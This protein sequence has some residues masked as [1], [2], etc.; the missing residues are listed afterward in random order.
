[1]SSSSIA[2]PPLVDGDL[3]LRPP[4]EADVAA[5][6]RLCQDPDVQRFTRVPSPYTEN[7]ARSFL[8]LHADGIE[9]GTGVHLLTV[10]ITTDEVLGAV[11]GDI[12]HRDYSSEVGYWVGPDARGRGIATRGTRLLVRFLLDELDIRY[13]MLHAA[14]DNPAS[15]AVARKLGFTHEGTSRDAMLLGPTGDL[16]APRGDANLWGLRPGELT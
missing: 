1:V 12:D 14:V 15:N 16:S 2:L 8:A 7:D 10:D 5:I 6:T 4:R 3:T 11:G 13:V 9:D